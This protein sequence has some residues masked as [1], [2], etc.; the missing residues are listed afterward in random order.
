M[1]LFRE[2]LF[3]DVYYIAVS[4][5]SSVSVVAS[6]IL[7][8]E[9]LEIYGEKVKVDAL[10]LNMICQHWNRKSQAKK[11]NKDQ[12]RSSLGTLDALVYKYPGFYVRFIYF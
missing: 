10:V 4:S 5:H 7:F 3:Q 11:V 1:F 2:K 9:I 8:L 12:I 6:C